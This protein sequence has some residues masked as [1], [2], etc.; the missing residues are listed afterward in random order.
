[1]LKL[2]YAALISL[3]IVTNIK[4]IKMAANGYTGVY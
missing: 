1:M 3:I 4:I 2:S